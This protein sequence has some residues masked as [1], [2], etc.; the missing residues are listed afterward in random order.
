[1]NICACLMLL[2]GFPIAAVCTL[3]LPLILL[4]VIAPDPH[5]W[6]WATVYLVDFCYGLA[7][8]AQLI[9]FLRRRAANRL[10]TATVGGYTVL[11]FGQTALEALLHL[12]GLQ[13]APMANGVFLFCFMSAGLCLGV[14]MLWIAFR[15]GDCWPPISSLQE[16]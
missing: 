7:L 14:L 10:W 13:P 16:I 8:F 5:P 11:A 3:S 1:M 4:G 12:A 15:H 2:L 6:N 9:G